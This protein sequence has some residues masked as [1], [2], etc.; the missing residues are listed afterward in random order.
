MRESRLSR[1]LLRTLAAMFLLFL[2]D[3]CWFLLLSVLVNELDGRLISA[4]W[5]VAR[6][7]LGLP[8]GLRIGLLLLSLPGGVFCPSYLIPLGLVRKGTLSL[9]LTPGGRRQD[10][11]SRCRGSCT[12]QWA[13]CGTGGRGTYLLSRFLFARVLLSPPVLCEI[14]TGSC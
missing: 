2:L 4:P 3:W 10:R 5:T 14:C 11:L 9:Y 6:G 1:S 7:G 13:P 12:A 8:S